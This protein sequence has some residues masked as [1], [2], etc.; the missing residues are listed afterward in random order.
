VGGGFYDLATLG[1][2]HVIDGSQPMVPEAIARIRAK[3][4]LSLDRRR[5][6]R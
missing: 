2:K 3:I 1:A 6:A 4:G 5:R